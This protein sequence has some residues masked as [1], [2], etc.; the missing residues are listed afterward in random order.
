MPVAPTHS[1]QGEQTMLVQALGHVVLKVRDLQR[2]EAFYSGALGI[3]IIS[4]ISHPIYMTFFTLGNHHDFAIKEVGEDAPL[5][6]PDATGLAHVAFKIGD[7]IDEFRSVKTELDAAGITIL[8]E[9]DR[10][11]TKSLHL[12][13]PDENE[14]ELYIDTSDTWKTNIEPVTSAHISPR[15]S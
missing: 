2:S 10:V 13:D 8:Y 7:S 12:H 14:I 1:P 4:R 3:P 15:N 5:P 11:F 9:A 6:D